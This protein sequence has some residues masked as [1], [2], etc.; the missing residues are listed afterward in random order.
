MKY[1][2]HPHAWKELREAGIHYYSASAEAGESFRDEISKSISRI[3]SF[4]EAWPKIRGEIRRCRVNR[5]PYGVIYEF[6]GTHVF[7]LPVMHLNRRP[8]YWIDRI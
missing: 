2:F 6:D 4:P 1:T 8:N 5:F 7:I 3:L